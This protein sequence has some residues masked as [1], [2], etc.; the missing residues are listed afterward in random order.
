MCYM[1]SKVNNRIN[2]QK[3][4]KQKTKFNAFHNI[5]F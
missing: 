2:D 1:T 5:Q 4:K 3:N